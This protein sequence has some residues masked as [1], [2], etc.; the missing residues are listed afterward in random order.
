MIAP[1]LHHSIAFQDAWQKGHNG[2]NKC[3][4]TFG[5]CF[6][7]PRVWVSSLGCVWALTFRNCTSTNSLHRALVGAAAIGFLALAPGSDGNGKGTKAASKA[8]SKTQIPTLGA[9]WVR[10]R[11]VEGSKQEAKVNLAP[12]SSKE[13]I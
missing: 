11:R 10:E 8:R 6:G 9:W 13:G 3:N 2:T 5:R 4:D 12:N 7:R 1:Q